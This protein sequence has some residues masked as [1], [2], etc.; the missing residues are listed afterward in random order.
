MTEEIAIK[1]IWFPIIK[2]RRALNCESAKLEHSLAVKVTFIET[3]YFS[4]VSILKWAQISSLF[5]LLLYLTGKQ[6]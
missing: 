2:Q 4:Q 5:S 3:L 1:A 6:A